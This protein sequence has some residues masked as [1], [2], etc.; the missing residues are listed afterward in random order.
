MAWLNLRNK[1][2]DQI[3]DWQQLLN[4][5]MNLLS[6]NCREKPATGKNLN[7]ELLGE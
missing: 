5:H 4:I 3:S 1:E 7:E 2:D 6:N